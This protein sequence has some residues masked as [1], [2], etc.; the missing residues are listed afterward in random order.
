M[1]Q[2]VRNIPYDTSVLISPA[3]GEII[4]IIPWDSSYVDIDE[5]DKKAFDLYTKDI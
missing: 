5:K 4:S 1:R 3:H 2:P